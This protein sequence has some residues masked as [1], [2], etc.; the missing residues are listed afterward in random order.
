MKVMPL[1]DN[2]Q[3]LYT[4]GDNLNNSKHL[5]KEIHIV[6][7]EWIVRVIIDLLEIPTQMSKSAYLDRMN[8]LEHKKRKQS[9]IEK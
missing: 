3:L 7:E 2:N 9:V 5:L 1:L 8:I 6:K 4:Q